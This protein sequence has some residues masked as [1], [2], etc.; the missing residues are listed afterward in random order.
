MLIVCHL[1][2]FS[3]AQPAPALMSAYHA[4][5]DTPTMA[6]VCG[7]LPHGENLCAILNVLWIHSLAETSVLGP[8]RRYLAQSRAPW[9]ITSVFTRLSSASLRI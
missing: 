4:S 5:C 7:L 6:G 1:A 2:S 3:E 8:K 9:P